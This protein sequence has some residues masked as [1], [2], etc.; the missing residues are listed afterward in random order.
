MGDLGEMLSFCLQVDCFLYGQ[1]DTGVL[2]R[3]IRTRPFW[4][5]VGK[6]ICFLLRSTLILFT[7]TIFYNHQ[8]DADTF[9]CKAGI[10]PTELLLKYIRYCCMISY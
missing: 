1:P 10:E 6:R 3:G 4:L 8:P 7:E 5:K 9:V 2:Q